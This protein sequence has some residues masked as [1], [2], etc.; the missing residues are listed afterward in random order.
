M[1]TIKY[2]LFLNSIV[3]IANFVEET[4]FGG[5]MTKSDADFADGRANTRK[6]WIEQ[7]ISESK[8][9][10]AEKQKVA[11]ETVELTRDLDAEW[12]A[13]QGKMKIKGDLYSKKEKEG[14]NNLAHILSET[15]F[16]Q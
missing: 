11:E 12:K 6:E 1:F 4:H 16:S 2:V 10:K 14:N 13:L 9:K 3:S 5:F 8:K 15:R 7:M